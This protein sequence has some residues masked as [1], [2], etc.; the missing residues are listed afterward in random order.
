MMHKSCSTCAQSNEIRYRHESSDF[1]RTHLVLAWIQWTA[2]KQLSKN[3][4]KRPHVDGHVVANAKD[5]LW[6]A[7]ESRLDIGVH[8]LLLKATAA[9]INNLD[10]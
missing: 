8:S 5:D 9:E 4:S 3:A 2:G 6:G 10:A 1:S 7:I